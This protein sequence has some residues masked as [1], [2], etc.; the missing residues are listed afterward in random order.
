MKTAIEWLVNQISSSKY[1]YKVM[2]DI[3][4]RSTV[5]QSNIFEQAKAMEKEQMCQFVSDYLDDGQDMTAEE[6]YEQTYKLY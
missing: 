6:Y 2:E 4:S 3:Q 5:A 1:F